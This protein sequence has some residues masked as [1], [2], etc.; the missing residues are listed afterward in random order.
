MYETG[1]IRLKGKIQKINEVHEINIRPSIQ[2]PTILGPLKMVFMAY[3]LK[4][5]IHNS[6][7]SCK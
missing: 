6:N 5:L 4:P 2:G 1:P 7:V 3:N